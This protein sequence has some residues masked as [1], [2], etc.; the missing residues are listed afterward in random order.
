MRFGAHTSCQPEGK[1]EVDP[2]CKAVGISGL[3]VLWALAS[4]QCSWAASSEEVACTCRKSV[5]TLGPPIRRH[6]VP[7]PSSGLRKPD[8]HQVP[9]L[10]G[11]QTLAAHNI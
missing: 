4:E 7:F 5:G 8:T 9:P 6:D 3:P 11:A 10:N 1:T 2:K